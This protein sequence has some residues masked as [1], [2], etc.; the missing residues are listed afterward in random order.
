MKTMDASCSVKAENLEVPP[1]TV[2][3]KMIIPGQEALQQSTAGW[4]CLHA[5]WPLALSA[6]YVADL[7]LPLTCPGIQP[8]FGHQ[9]ASTM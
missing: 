9:P 5:F 7:L 3:T 4:D 8:L 6:V 2:A 1:V